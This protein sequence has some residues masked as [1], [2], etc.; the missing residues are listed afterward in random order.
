[1]LVNSVAASGPS[2]G[3]LRKGDVITE[4]GFEKVSGLD[5]AYAALEPAKAPPG[6]PLLLR[7]NRTGQTMFF[8]IKTE[9]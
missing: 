1:V 5:D 7:I 3:K 6:K 2:F 9:R 8:T 4:M